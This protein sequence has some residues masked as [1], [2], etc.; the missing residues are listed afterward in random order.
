[1]KMRLFGVEKESSLANGRAKDWSMS[2]DSAGDHA[3]DIVGFVGA[4]VGRVWTLDTLRHSGSRQ[5]SARPTP[6]QA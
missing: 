2:A 5:G 1:M 3:A 4:R 6:S